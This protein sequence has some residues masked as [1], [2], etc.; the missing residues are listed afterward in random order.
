MSIGSDTT[1]TR[2]GSGI[3]DTVMQSA[4]GD[5]SGEMFLGMQRTGAFRSS[6]FGGTWNQ[7]GVPASLVRSIAAFSCGGSDGTLLAGLSG[8]GIARSTNSGLQWSQTALITSTPSSF[9]Q[10]DSGGLIIRLFAGSD[11]GIHRSTDMGL[12]WTLANAGL[13]NTFVY[14]VAV[15]P[16]AG[17]AGFVFAG[18]AGGGVFRSTDYGT[19]W[20][21]TSLNNTFARTL[22]INSG[23]TIFVG[24]GGGGVLRSTDDGETWIEASWG[25]TNTIIADLAINH[26]EHVFAATSGCGVF[27]STD[28]GNSWSECNVGLT[29]LY[30]RDLAIPACPGTEG[31]LYAATT[32]GVFRSTDNGASWTQINTGV[33]SIAANAVTASHPG[34]TNVYAF[35]GT[36]G[37]GVFRSVQSIVAVND[38]TC[39]DPRAFELE[40]NYPNPFNPSTK[41][42][43]RLHVSGFTSLKVY[44]IVGREVAM[45]VNK[46]MLAGRYEIE[47]KPEGLTSGVYLCRLMSG[48]LTEVKKLMLLR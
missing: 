4:W 23:G 32:S 18:T 28:D 13:T 47:W 25:L 16:T 2:I 39:A 20:A 12:T 8:M 26:A 11:V 27:V 6:N 46:E 5:S 1:W 44:D 48:N 3:V 38:P 40:Q 24:T 41:I 34:S 9:A 37:S 45:L 7:V 33:G 43:F 10:S 31:Q 42:G 36:E 21:A 22:A 17:S 14:S 19:S 29:N 35:A 30:V 15:P